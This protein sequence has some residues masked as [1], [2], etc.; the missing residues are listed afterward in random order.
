[1]LYILKKTQY[2]KIYTTKKKK[3]PDML[4]NICNDNTFWELL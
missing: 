1:M 4:K 3:I 2:P